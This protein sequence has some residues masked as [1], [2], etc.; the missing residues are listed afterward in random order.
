MYTCSAH[1]IHMQYY[2]I[3]PSNLLRIDKQQTFWQG[4][5]HLHIRNALDGSGSVTESS[6]LFIQVFSS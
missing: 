6:H 5:P 2:N 3:L 4:T 1:Y